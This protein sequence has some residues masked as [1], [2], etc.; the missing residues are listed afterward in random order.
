MQAFRIDIE[1][2][3]ACGDSRAV[4]PSFCVRKGRIIM[5][6]DNKLEQVVYA[7][8]ARRFG[9]EREDFRQPGTLVLKEKELA[10][11]GKAHLYHIDRMSVLRADPSLAEQA[12]LADGCS[13][14]SG[15]L[16]ASQL[17]AL[18]PVGVES[19]FL[20]YYLDARDLKLFPVPAP[21]TTRRLDAQHED[22]LLLDL[23]AACTEPELDAADIDA[24]KPDAVICG[25][26]AGTRLAAYAGYRVWEEHFADIGVLIHPDDRGR[27]LG[28]A[29]VS[30]LCEWCLGD[31]VLVPMYRVF[32]YN[33]HS[34][35]IAQSLGFREM[36]V[37]ETLKSGEAAP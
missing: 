11:T 6:T 30:T 18:A 17:Q 19:T 29:V 25:L 15:S 12:G 2:V 1:A 9:C 10:G 32:S 34:C 35:R 3:Y 5:K 23:Y 28:K 8:W 33:A 4:P 37:I 31:D 7:Y 20:D 22:S 13:R 16:S 21:F 36:V 27:G 26:F 24:D 14:D